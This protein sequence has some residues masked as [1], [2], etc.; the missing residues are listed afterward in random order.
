MYVGDHPLNDVDPANRVGMVSV[1]NKR[2]RQAYRLAGAHQAGTTRSTTSSI[3]L[4]LLQRDFGFDF[5]L[6]L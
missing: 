4:D 3:S 5:D 6:E 2:G 1:W